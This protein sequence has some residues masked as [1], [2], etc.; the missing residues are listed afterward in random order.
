MVKANKLGWEMS[1]Q[2]DAL[3][4]SKK[5]MKALNSY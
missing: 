5:I 2:T 4:K 1:I 3:K